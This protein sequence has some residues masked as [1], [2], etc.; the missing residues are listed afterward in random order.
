MHRILSVLFL[1]AIP[2]F[3]VAFPEP[4]SNKS[5]PVYVKTV[6]HPDLALKYAEYFL[7]NVIKNAD[8]RPF[9]RF[10]WWGSTPDARLVHDVTTSSVYL[11]TVNS[12]TLVVLG[13]PV[14]GTDFRL[15][16]YDIRDLGWTINAFSAVARRDKVFREPNVDHYLAEKVRRLIG[17]AQDPVTFH[18]EAIVPGPW[19]LWTIMNPGLSQTTNYYDLLYS[20]ERFGTDQIGSQLDIDTT[21]KAAV[22]VSTPEPVKPAARPWPGGVWKDDG[23]YYPAG[24]F[25]YIP[26]AEM[27]GWEKDHAAWEA[28]KNKPVNVPGSGGPKVSITLPPGSVFKGKVI[29]DFPENLQQF[30]D[31]WGRTANRAFLD[32]QKIFVNKGAIVAGK[33]NDPKRGSYVAYNDRIIEI[34]NGEFNNGGGNMSTRDFDRTSRR[35]N[36]ANLPTET[37]LGLLEEDAGENLFT[38]PNG[39]QAALIHGAAPE[40]KRVDHA[41]S[42]FVHASLDPR[43]VTIWDGYSSCAI[44]HARFGGVLEPSNNRVNEAKAKGVRLNFL[45]KNDQLVTESFFNLEEY[46]LE[47]IRMPFREAVKKATSIADAP[48]WNGVQLAEA[49]VS[50][51]G[52]YNQPIDIYQASAELGVPPLVTLLACAQ[53]LGDQGKKADNIGNFGSKAL[54]VDFPIGRAEFD[55]DVFPEL[56]KVISIMRNIEN[57]NPI[58]AIMYP[59]LLRQTIEQVPGGK[60]VGPSLKGKK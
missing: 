16:F 40:R 12:Q 3:A 2:G 44:C 47:Q 21:A 19:L 49:T 54:F 22:A 58:V 51:I 10:T 7:T 43:D 23:K 11:N 42:K 50:F 35:K 60:S 8:D 25:N 18:A 53:V 55:D 39:L 14:P 41:D 5:R 31:R 9:I 45:N 34:E 36:P 38:L 13:R 28:A 48:P 4:P 32:G 27:Q 56:A 37:A 30:Q 6:T 52:W 1:L 29:K 59:E 33:Y 26:I 20:F 57:P 17:V 24:A 15:W 46:R